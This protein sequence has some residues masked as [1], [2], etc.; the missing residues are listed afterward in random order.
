M[1]NPEAV[2]EVAET[3]LAV[4][5]GRVWEG[6]SPEH[7]GNAMHLISLLPDGMDMRPA[8]HVLWLAR[9]VVV[10]RPSNF[11]AQCPCHWEWPPHSMVFL[12]LGC[13]TW[14][15]QPCMPW[16]T[17]SHLL[18]SIKRGSCHHDFFHPPIL[19]GRIP[20][21]WDC[22]LLLWELLLVRDSTKNVQRICVFTGLLQPE[23]T[24]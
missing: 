5:T 23:L 16:P 20:L 17:L 4:A 19:A 7:R 18:F 13:L 10:N 21:T 6:G 15:P 2:S 14:F 1:S 22:I 12:P 8:N 3:M 11:S 24:T 9:P